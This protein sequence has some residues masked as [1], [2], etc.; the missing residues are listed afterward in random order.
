VSLVAT[1]VADFV[2]VA[3]MQVIVDS[4][5]VY[6]FVPGIPKD[7]DPDHTSLVTTALQGYFGALATPAP[8]TAAV[9]GKSTTRFFKVVTVQAGG[10]SAPSSAGTSAACWTDPDEVVTWTASGTETGGYKILYSPDGLVAY[11]QVGTVAHGAALSFHYA[12]Q[13][14]TT[15]APQVGGTVPTGVTVTAQT[16]SI[17]F[18]RV[19]Q[20]I[21]SGES[22]PS[23]G[24][25]VATVPATPSANN[26]VH[27]SWTRETG[28]TATRILA[29]SLS[30]GTGVGSFDYTGQSGSSYTPSGSNPNLVVVSNGPADL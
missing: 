24:T 11:V 10:D 3:V 13:A 7:V 1:P 26:R 6:D 29:G 8:P 19:A 16:Q 15:Y 17:V 30:V 28:E 22:I 14:G 12:G 9:Q 27:L 21:G 4:D 2:N 25:T 20:T 23:A 18:K 5:V